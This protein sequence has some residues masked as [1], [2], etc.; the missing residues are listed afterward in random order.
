MALLERSASL[1]WA[2]EHP[3]L[4]EFFSQWRPAWMARGLCRGQVTDLWFPSQ[5]GDLE[6]PKAICELCPV[7]AECRAYALARPAL[8]GIWGGTSDRERMRMRKARNLRG[9][10]GSGGLET[11]GTN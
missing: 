6:T 10:D 5:G 9:S 4:E 2:L 8:M 11:C 7:L 1:P 3:D